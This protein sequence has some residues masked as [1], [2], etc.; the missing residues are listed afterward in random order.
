MKNYL[1]IV[2][3]NESGG[4]HATRPQDLVF[5]DDTDRRSVEEAMHQAERQRIRAC[6]EMGVDLAHQRA[7]R[8]AV[9]RKT[10]WLELDQY[11][12]VVPTKKDWWGSMNMVSLKDI[13]DDNEAAA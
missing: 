3:T 11:G 13:T 10:I 4:S 8:I 5:F 7:P 6:L 12:V 1:K 9:G 2:K